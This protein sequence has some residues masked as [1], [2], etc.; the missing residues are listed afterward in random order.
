MSKEIVDRQQVPRI[1]SL[2]RSIAWFSLFLLAAAWGRTLDEQGQEVW[3]LAGAFGL[4]AAVGQGSLET[5][6]LVRER[7]VQDLVSRVNFERTEGRLTQLNEQ[8]AG[9]ESI[10]DAICRLTRHIAS[11]PQW[12]AVDP[13][14][15]KSPAA[16]SPF[17]LEVVPVENNGEAFD[18]GSA[19]SIAGSLRSIL[20]R[21]V[22]FEHDHIFSECVA[23][24]TFTLRNREKLCFVVDVM[25]TNTLSD[26]FVSSGAVMAVG[27]PDDKAPEMALVEACQE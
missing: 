26:R 11:E 14:R 19:R 5:A 18:I 1:S 2:S 17:P 20:S 27:V 3:A 22:T 23:L 12:Q 10:D 16:L 8:S 4:A 13:A 15:G 7:Y 9:L 21:V 6:R 25:W 24:L